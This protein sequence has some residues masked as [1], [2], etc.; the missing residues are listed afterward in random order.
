MP[1][2]FQ[3]STGGIGAMADPADNPDGHDV[4]HHDAGLQVSE[5]VTNVGDEAG[6]A[7]VGWEVDDVFVTD[8]STSDLS[9][10]QSE[11]VYASLGRVGAG[12]HRVLAYV[13]PGSG[14]ADHDTNDLE[15]A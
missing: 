9:P 14:T 5:E 13:N 15:I 11:V 2:M 3:L 10:G 12:A 7:T 8:V 4:P 6:T 1:A